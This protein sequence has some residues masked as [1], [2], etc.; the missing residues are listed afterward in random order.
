MVAKV[1]AFQKTS[2]TWRLTGC[3]CLLLLENSS[4][5]LPEIKRWRTLFAA[6]N[7]SK[8]NLYS[9]YVLDFSLQVVMRY[10]E[11]KHEVRLLLPLGDHLVSADTGGDVIVWDVQ[12][13]GEGAGPLCIPVTLALAHHPFPVPQTSTC[14]WNLTVPPLTCQP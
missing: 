14:G 11:H 8:L 13:G 6:S 5:P 7:T 1:T 4:V 10:Q 9:F 2:A 12:G 3:W